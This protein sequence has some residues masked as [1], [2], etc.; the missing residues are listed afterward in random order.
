MSVERIDQW[1]DTWKMGFWFWNANVISILPL[2]K[3]EV[4]PFHVKA[5]R[6]TAGQNGATKE[7]QSSDFI[8][9]KNS[10][11]VKIAIQ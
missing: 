2:L 6:I 3:S 8:S 10:N 1:H 9:Y 7:D 4:R 5:E 11:H